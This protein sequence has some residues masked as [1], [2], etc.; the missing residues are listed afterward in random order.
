MTG[1]VPFSPLTVE[2]YA[3]RKALEQWQAACDAARAA[4]RARPVFTGPSTAGPPATAGVRLV[5]PGSHACWLTQ[6]QNLNLFQNPQAQL[7]Q[8]RYSPER[9]LRGTP[10]CPLTC[11]CDLPVCW[12]RGLARCRAAPHVVSRRGV[13]RRGVAWRGVA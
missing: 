10:Q 9:A 2:A 7:A 11:D 3:R 1:P 12:R 5:G 8:Q 13:A 4:G 6:T